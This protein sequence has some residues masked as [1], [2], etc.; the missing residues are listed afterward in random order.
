M[1]RQVKIWRPPTDVYET[2]TAIVVRVE[3][4]GMNEDDFN[5]ELVRRTLIVSGRR[6]DQASGAK[7]AYQQ[8]EIMYGD[9]RTEVYLPWLINE[10]AVEAT[11]RDGFLLIVLPKPKA[12]KVPIVNV[13]DADEPKEAK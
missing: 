12:F 8:M 4:A 6:V 2:D 3:I 11:Y 10:A 9:F 5:I 1:N 7:L 13:V